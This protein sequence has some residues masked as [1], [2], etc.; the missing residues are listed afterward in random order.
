MILRTTLLLLALGVA[1]GAVAATDPMTG[2]PIPAAAPRDVA[3]PE[4]TMTPAG[5]TGDLE[6]LAHL[7][8]G[9]TKSVRLIG[10]VAVWQNGAYLEAHDVSVPG[11]PVALSRYLLP[12]QPSDME[13]VGD[14]LYVALRKDAGLLVLD[15]ADP[16]A[17]AVAASLPGEDL[18][19]VAVAGDLAYCGAGSAGF[20]VIDLAAPGGPAQIAA[21]DTP[22]SA[23][24]TAVMGNTLLVALGNNGFGTY[25][26]TDPSAPAQLALWA[27]DGFCTYV[28]EDGGVAYLAGNFGLQILDVSDPTN[29]TPLGSYDPGD[30][31]YELV[32][33]GEVLYVAGL[34]GLVAVL[35]TDPANPIA[36]DASTVTNGFSC[37]V[38]ESV[39]LMGVRFEGLYVLD[40]GSL[41][42]LSNVGNAGFA[43]KLHL[44][45]D[46]LY[47][48]DLSGGVLVWDVS[49]PEN[50][51]FLTEIA[52]EPNTQDVGIAGDQL[53]IVNANNTG[54]GL[55]MAD[56]SDPAAPVV[57]GARD[58]GNQTYGIDLVGPRA[59]LANGFGGL[60]VADVS[61]PLA[62]VSLGDL[63]LGAAAFDVMTAGDVAYVASFGGGFLAVDVSDPAG[64]AILDQELW[65]FLNAV[66]VT[67]QTAWVADGQQG[68]RVVDITDPADL[69]S[70]AT[71]P[72][73]SQARDV[74][75]SRVGS[76]YVY[77]GD[78]FYGLRQV[79]VS[80]PA[81]PVLLGSYPSADRGM[82]VD[83]VGGLV[84][85]A[86]GETGVYIYRNPAV[87]PAMAGGLTARAN[88]D[89]VE[90]DLW[91][92]QPH[93]H[94]VTIT[95]TT[96]DPA[97]RRVFTAAHL[98]DRREGP[99]T[100]RALL[101]DGD[102]A[103]FPR[104]YHLEVT[105]PSG[106]KVDL[107]RVE[108]DRAVPMVQTLTAAPNPFNPRLEIAFNLPRAGHVQVEVFDARG[109]LVR[110][111]LQA[112]A[113]AG[114]GTL[115]WNGD[116][117]GGRPVASGVYHLRLTA[118]DPL[119]PSPRGA[120]L[121]TSRAPSHPPRAHSRPR[122]RQRPRPARRW[123]PVDQPPRCSATI[124]SP[125]STSTTPPAA[126][127][128]RPTRRPRRPPARQPTSE[129]M[130]ATTPITSAG[131]QTGSP[132]QAKLKPTASASR[133][134]ATARPRS[135]RPR[136]GSSVATPSG[137]SRSASWIMC[138]PIQTSRA[139]ATQ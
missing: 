26:I 124:L 138:P 98:Q 54:T 78:D 87:V 41:D 139:K 110:T 130:A 112:D 111:L 120:R 92:S 84:V 31:T 38:N 127:M 128:R 96:D 101:R 23:N 44:S 25:D 55:L 95:R 30:T 5:R 118:P 15:Y 69:V 4:P 100:S 9:T 24:G 10:D 60:M 48:A 68:L 37:A 102:H 40:P 79:D 17:P 90:L 83:A 2:E 35:V 47:V 103:G 46:A 72:L 61:D 104:T 135:R 43:N 45:G 109:R 32:K 13:V 114:A 134:V 133:L 77:L 115:I 136:V 42:V 6:L 53:A 14:R 75:R 129:K 50:P 91:L 117:A 93:L 131:R 65:G 56:V 116:D 22:G 62:P 73:A 39:V 85:L 80:D 36:L 1:V 132:R 74:V 108:V 11:S 33:Q 7:A 125:T 106:E 121:T 34:Q 21:L 81:N 3:G 67:D 71:L 137:C 12:A 107:D 29:P 8:E 58:T 86:A 27:T 18:L 88:Q 113:P 19:S 122:R 70:V 16:A 123:P 126:S 64:M 76:P 63:F 105:L 94:G 51:V 20:V 99:G 66:D 119:R 82:G 57:Q 28:R 59:V 97:E 52:S 89:A 49:D